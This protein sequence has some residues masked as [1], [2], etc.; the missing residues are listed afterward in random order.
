MSISISISIS[1]GVGGSHVKPGALPIWAEGQLLN[2]C[3]SGLEGGGGRV[4]IWS[5]HVEA[6]F[7]MR[8]H[9]LLA[10]QPLL[11]ARMYSPKLS[12]MSF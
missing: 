12:P 6:H 3:G 11:G 1:S 2:A 5:S 8:P 9:A 10:W 7:V 4:Q